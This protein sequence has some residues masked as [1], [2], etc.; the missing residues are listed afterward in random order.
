MRC[1]FPDLPCNSKVEAAARKTTSEL[2]MDVG[3]NTGNLVFRH[4]IAAQIADELQPCTFQEAVER[5][6]QEQYD[7][8]VVAAANW[9]HSSVPFGNG[10][11][12]KSLRQINL[13]IICIGLGCQHSSSTK[14][15][16][17]FN[18]ET[19]ELLQTLV[20]LEACVLVR[21]EMTLAQCRHYGLKNV[22]L[23]GCPSNFMNHDPDFTKKLTERAQRTSFPRVSLNIG[24]ETPAVQEHDIKL[25]PLVMAGGGRLV[26]QTN[27][28]NIVAVALNRRSEY[29][30]ADVKSL[31]RAFRLSLPMSLLGPSFQD[32]REFTD[33]YF[34]VPR[35]IEDAG[36]WDLVLGSRV[37]GAIAA[38]QACTPAILTTIDARTQG[39]A[40]QMQIP[41]VCLENTTHWKKGVKV[42]KIIEEAPLDFS[43][44][45]ARR[46]VLVNEYANVLQNFGLTLSASFGKMVTCRQSAS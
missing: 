20:D 45:I 36:E 21:D 44:Y 13:P 12:A 15:K 24:F 34:D 28:H 11:R 30:S 1:L 37:H 43:A 26:I 31:K 42:S 9:L 40:E 23:I 41:H 19:R 39:L 6:K 7:A 32:F 25:L 5:A 18:E 46:S 8:V 27:Y 33:I 17:P 10:H 2:M 38:L 16:L 14:E 29:S 4:A 35:W 22:F 3:A